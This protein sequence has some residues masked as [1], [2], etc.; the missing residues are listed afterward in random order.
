MNLKPI[1]GTA[2]E[3]WTSMTGREILELL[4][5]LNTSGRTILLITHDPDIASY[6]PR[7]VHLMDGRVLSDDRG[8]SIKAMKVIDL[9]ESSFRSILFTN[10]ALFRLSWAS[11]SAALWL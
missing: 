11:S 4:R 7:I 5:D 2:P 6:A 9:L 1:W 3:T 10:C 8:R